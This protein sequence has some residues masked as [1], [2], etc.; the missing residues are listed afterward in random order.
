MPL[1]DDRWSKGKCGLKALQYMALGIPTICSPVGVNIDII[2]DGRNGL[3]A[4]TEDE[5]IAKLKQLLRSAE[6]RR[7][8]GRAG[9]ATVEAQYSALVQAP[10][11]YRILES[12]VG[13]RGTRG[14]AVAGAS[15]PAPMQEQL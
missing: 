14:E 9:R 15:S 6:L 12:V 10:R 2:Q 11:V 8:L 13:Q 7:S 5:W 4:A 3:I 1:P